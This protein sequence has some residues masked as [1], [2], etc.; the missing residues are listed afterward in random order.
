MFPISETLTLEKGRMMN[1]E[2]GVETDY[3]EVWDD[4]TPGIVPGTEG[5]TCVV[6]RMEK[7]RDRGLMVVLGRHC[8][9][10]VRTEEGVSAERW[11]YE[12]GWKRVVRTGEEVLCEDVLRKLP[13][14]SVGQRHEVAGRAWDVVELA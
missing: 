3:E 4:M 8:Q 13:G 11:E 2:T 1:P 10:L 9:A 6:L 7:G 12:G 14:L 5:V